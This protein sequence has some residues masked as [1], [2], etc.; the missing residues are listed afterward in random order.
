MRCFR[1]GV[2]GRRVI[3]EGEGARIG[4]EMAALLTAIEATAGLL[5]PDRRP[6][7]R[8]LS[9]L[10]EGADRIAARVALA[11]GWRLDL[12]LPFPAAEYARD[13]A[14]APGSL[15]EFHALLRRA[16]DSGGTCRELPGRREDAT[17]AYAAVGR[18]TAEAS[19]LLLAVLDEAPSRGPGGTRDTVRAALARGVPTWW[20]HTRPGRDPVLLEDATGLGDRVTL[21]RMD[22][23]RR[24]A[25]RLG[26]LL[27]APA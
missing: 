1:L 20:V 15:E 9:P 26:A 27:A 22:N 21:E 4:T 16:V 7:L 24:L 2:T 19:D 18:A 6:A 17:G 3:P 8:L 23:A 11:R 12:L 5:P 13:F 10:A 25:A 14:A